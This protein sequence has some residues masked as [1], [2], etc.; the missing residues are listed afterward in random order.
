MKILSAPAFVPPNLVL[1]YFEV[2]SNDI[3]DIQQDMDNGSHLILQ[4]KCG[5][6]TS[7]HSL[8]FHALMML[9]KVGIEHSNILW[10]MLI[11]LFIN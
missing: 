11:Q 5:Q 6:C 1:H 8:D 2:L 10:V 7:K 4:L 3:S 9:L